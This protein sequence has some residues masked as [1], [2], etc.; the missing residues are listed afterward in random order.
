MKG[1]APRGPRC[2]FSKCGGRVLVVSGREPAKPWFDEFSASAGPYLGGGGGGVAR[3][4]WS[5]AKA[6]V[7]PGSTGGSSG[8]AS[9]RVLAAKASE[10][11]SVQVLSEVSAPSVLPSF[12]T[13]AACCPYCRCGRTSL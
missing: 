8:P 7:S 11:F 6:S 13:W 10:L 1:L 3:A 9:A 4:F 12:S 5:R 2:G